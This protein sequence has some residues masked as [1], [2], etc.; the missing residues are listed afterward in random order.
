M[1]G[2]SCCF[3]YSKRVFVY[4]VALL[5][6]PSL[7]LFSSII[8]S[9]I[10]TLMLHW[11]WLLYRILLA[12]LPYVYC[13]K[14]PL[15]FCN[16]LS[17]QRGAAD[18]AWLLTSSPQPQSLYSSGSCCYGYRAWPLPWT[19]P[20]LVE[21]HRGWCWAQRHGCSHTNKHTPVCSINMKDW[22]SPFIIVSDW[23]LSYLRA[24]K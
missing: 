23:H 2:A 18:Y 8:Q 19:K 14:S 3:E 12:I 22:S 10:Y 9:H 21:E 4:V 7:Y 6:C 1:L 16:A 15:C 20:H 24:L 17:V 5:L 11:G 13:V